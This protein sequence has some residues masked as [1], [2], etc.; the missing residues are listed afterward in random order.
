MNA[1]Q[2]ARGALDSL[3]DNRGRSLRHLLI[4]LGVTAGAVAASAMIARRTP[5]SEDEPEAYTDYQPA[6]RRRVVRPKNLVTLLWPP[7]FLALTISGVR[8]WRAPKSEAR[9]QALTLWAFVQ[10]L[11]AVWMALGTRRLGGRL[12]TATSALGTAGAF[13]W[14]AR[15]VDT[16]DAG[17]GAPYVGWVGVASALSGELR[18]KGGPKPTIH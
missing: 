7:L 17:A 8:I 4:G 18:R 12:A 15:R 1:V 16:P 14:R 3:A 9:S 10:G 13:A 5:A 11:N 6:D 2:A